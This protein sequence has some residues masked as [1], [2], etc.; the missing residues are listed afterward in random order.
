MSSWDDLERPKRPEP[1][2]DEFAKHCAQVF[3][4]GP[5]VRLLEMFRDMTI[6]K[7][8]SAAASDR[9]LVGIEAQRQFVRRIEAATKI[10]LQVKTKK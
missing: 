3:S 10:G 1:E 6:E 7:Q 5:G 8:L 2:P 9:A 4:S